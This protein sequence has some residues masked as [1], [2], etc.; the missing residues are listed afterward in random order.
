MRRSVALGFLTIL[1]CASAAF[2]HASGDAAANTPNWFVVVPPVLAILVAVFTRN[3]FWALGSGILLSESLMVGFNLAQGAFLSI[4]R[5]VAVFE[6][7]GNTRIMMFCLLI[8]AL[9]AYM[10]DSGGVSAMVALLRRKGFASSRKRAQLAPAIA[11]SAIFIDTNASI[12]SSGILG[13]PLFDAY[14]IS[15]ERLAYIIDSTCA[16]ISVLILLNGWGAYALGLLE[17]H[18]F[19]NAVGIL[20]G[21]V[22]WNLYAILTVVM[23]YATVASDKVFGPMRYC[24]SQIDNKRSEQITEPTK[25]IYMWLPLLVLVLSSLGFMWLTG[26]GNIVAGSGSKS[27]LWAVSLSLFMLY[28]LLAFTRRYSFTELQERGFAGIAEMV[29]PVLVL[30]LSIT[31]GNSLRELGTADFLTS[32][33][34]A[35][36]MPGFIPAIV[37]VIAAITAFMTGTSWGTYGIMV[38]IAMPMAMAFGLPPSLMLAAVLGGG[39]AGDH[40]SPISDTTIISSLAAGCD[41]IDHVRT[42]LPYALVAGAATIIIYLVAG[43]VVLS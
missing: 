30:F 29:P 27:I 43:F 20:M 37:F 9:V 12:F 7:E 3:V 18:G 41:H 33:A 14:K 16:P 10:R 40:C 42:Q 15:R 11:G 21:S 36:I 25:A 24:E 5:A 26:N 23:V 17:P 31:L 19:D 8:G 6:S 2:V 32:V 4:D 28:L 22:P 35:S 13:R 39:V 1:F 38:P 34:Q